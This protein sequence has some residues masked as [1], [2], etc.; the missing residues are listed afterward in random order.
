[1]YITGWNIGVE[2]MD[3]TMNIDNTVV[4]PEA[5]QVK[6]TYRDTGN[7]DGTF[8]VY[9]S[10]IG[11]INGNM[12]GTATATARLI[13]HEQV[14]TQVDGGTTYMAA[15]V[16]EVLTLKGVMTFQYSGRTFRMG[17]SALEDAYM[18]GVPGVGI[19]KEQVRN[20]KV[21]VSVGIFSSTVS[22]KEWVDLIDY[23]P[24]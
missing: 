3:M 24:R 5:L 14:E 17:F 11:T 1:M 16:Q 7:F 4:A 6:Q 8:S 18:W 9:S 21:R 22:C 19:V 13:G 20:M 23:G 10:L 12:S 2:D 15:K